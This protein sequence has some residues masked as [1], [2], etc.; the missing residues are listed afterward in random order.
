MAS[1]N[2]VTLITV[3]EGLTL[4]TVDNLKRLLKLLPTKE[5]PT[6]KADLVSLIATYLA[7]PGLKKSW[8]DLDELQ[9]AAVSESVFVSVGFFLPYLF[10]A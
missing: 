4:K 6:K 3:T 1:S 7:G 2:Q 9:Q 5:R 8:Q 10:Q